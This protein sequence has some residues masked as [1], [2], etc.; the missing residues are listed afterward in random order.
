[1]T[2][3]YRFLEDSLASF[4]GLRL[5]ARALFYAPKQNT[6]DTSG[7][8]F[9]T[10]PPSFSLLLLPSSLLPPLSSLILPGKGCFNSE[11][12]STQQWYFQDGDCQ[13]E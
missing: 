8:I 7:L 12:V 11:E 5:P 3:Y 10:L 9:R 6:R 1:M 2:R 13:L 4:P